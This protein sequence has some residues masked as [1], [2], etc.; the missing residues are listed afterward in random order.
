VQEF[1]PAEFYRLLEAAEGHARQT[2]KTD[3][4][5]YIIAK[6]G[7]DQRADSLTGTCARSVILHLLTACR[8]RAVPHVTRP[9][10]SVVINVDTI[11]I[12][13]S[14]CDGDARSVGGG[15]G[16]LA[17]DTDGWPAGR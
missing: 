5:R 4:P 1:D 10:V 16:W 7:L 12:T 14:V 3:V 2:V 11:I 15:R 8:A 17:G 9:D 6:L 13:T